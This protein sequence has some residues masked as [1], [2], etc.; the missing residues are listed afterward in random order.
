MMSKQTKYV[1]ATKFHSRKLIT[2][3]SI[4]DFEALGSDTKAFIS[5]SEKYLTESRNKT[6]SEDAS[7]LVCAKLQYKITDV[8]SHSQYNAWCQSLGEFAATY[9]ELISNLLD[10]YQR[11][12]VKNFI[13]SNSQGHRTSGIQAFLMALL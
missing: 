8:L 12:L 4:P 10:V 2:G 7:E 11:N 9:D 1:L 6:K 13:D 5:A 3:I